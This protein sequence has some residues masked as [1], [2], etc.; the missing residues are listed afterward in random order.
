[1]VGKN[2]SSTKSSAKRPSKMLGWDKQFSSDW[3]TVIVLD[4]D[5]DKENV[6]VDPDILILEDDTKML[7]R[8]EHAWYNRE[9]E[10]F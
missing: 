8:W 2:K 6:E 1:M 10:T 3:G 9:W 4:S 7:D 5:D